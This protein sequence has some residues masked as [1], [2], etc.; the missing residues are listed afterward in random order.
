MKVAHENRSET[1]A[2]RWP[3]AVEDV[4]RICF[5]NIRISTLDRLKF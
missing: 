3:F 2:K 4:Y 1:M 5:L